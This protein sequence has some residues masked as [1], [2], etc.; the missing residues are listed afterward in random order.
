MSL[1]CPAVLQP[2]SA[3]DSKPDYDQ[4]TQAVV[5][6]LIFHLSAVQKTSEYGAPQIDCSFFKARLAAGMPNH[7]MKI[8]DSHLAC[9][10]SAASEF[11][12]RVYL[13]IYIC[14]QYNCISSLATFY[15]VTSMVLQIWHFVVIAASFENFWDADSNARTSLYSVKKRQ[16]LYTSFHTNFDVSHHMPFMFAIQHFHETLVASE[17][18]TD[19]DF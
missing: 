14:I 1:N 8:T 5:A 10:E 13:Y 12:A 18:W 16:L 6:S 4:P 17:I 11:L 19:G 9:S 15:N 3:I 2:L 7:F